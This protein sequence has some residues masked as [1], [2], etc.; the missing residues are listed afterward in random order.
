MARAQPSWEASGAEALG[1]VRAELVLSEA[2]YPDL[3]AVAARLLTSPRTLKRRLQ[4]AGSSFQVLLD[5]ARRRDA[6][7]LLEN[8][9][10]ELRQIASALGYS[11]PPSFTRAFLRWTGERPSAARRKLRA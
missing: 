2:G 7:R 4:Q 6:L 5:E 8:P 11:D 1:G 10:L 3:S 9:N